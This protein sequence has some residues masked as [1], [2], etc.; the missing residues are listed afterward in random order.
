MPYRQS[1]LSAT[2]K[3]LNAFIRAARRT[4]GDVSEEIFQSMIKTIPRALRRELI[5]NI[6]LLEAMLKATG[7]PQITW[8][9]ALRRYRDVRARGIPAAAGLLPEIVLQR[10]RDVDQVF[11]RIH[12]FDPEDHL[13]DPVEALA[14]SRRQRK[15]GEEAG[16]KRSADA[17]VE[18]DFRRPHIEE[19]IRHLAKIKKIDPQA[20]TL[21]LVRQELEKQGRR[22]PTLKLPGATTLNSEI[23]A[24]LAEMKK[25]DQQAG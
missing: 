24:V 4:G 11:A 6:E 23:K 10:A 18:R 2:M 17:R 7:F 25:T 19:A 14:L 12:A 22:N 1:S 20:L 5:E 8:H 13:C 3:S 9:E 21:S 15:S 16:A